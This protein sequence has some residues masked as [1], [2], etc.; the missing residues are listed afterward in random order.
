MKVITLD[1]QSEYKD[2]EHYYFGLLQIEFTQVSELQLWQKV[3]I[4]YE[5]QPPIE[6]IVTFI[7]Y[8]SIYA[9]LSLRRL[10]FQWIDKSGG[11]SYCIPHENV[12]L[13][14]ESGIDTLGP[15]VQLIWQA[16]LMGYK[17]QTSAIL[18]HRTQ[19]QLQAEAMLW[20]L[21]HELCGKFRGIFYIP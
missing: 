16:T 14:V 12:R 10:R 9:I 15:P 1:S 17:H 4:A 2:L 18:S 8:D 19:A 3:S 11:T 6:A 5:D 13:V 21:T 7:E 20:Q